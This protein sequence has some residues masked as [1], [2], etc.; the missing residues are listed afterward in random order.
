[1]TTSMNRPEN[2]KKRCHRCEEIFLLPNIR[3]SIARDILIE[4]M[5]CTHCEYV[6]NPLVPNGNLA[7]R[8]ADCKIAFTVVKYHSKGR[9]I[10]CS[11]AYQRSKCDKK[12]IT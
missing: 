3:E 12:H 8:C 2:I 9:C 7:G 4:F 5:P 11:R 1:M 6:K 10:R